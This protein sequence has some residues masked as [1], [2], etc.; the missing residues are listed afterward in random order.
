ME[1]GVS[2]SCPQGKHN[3]VDLNPNHYYAMV[4]SNCG[5]DIGG[6]GGITANKGK[7][8]WVAILNLVPKLPV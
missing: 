2:S 1:G 3:I 7:I 6:G 5:E 8:L 4:W